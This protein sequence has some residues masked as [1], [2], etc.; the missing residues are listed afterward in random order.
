MRSTNFKCSVLK[1]KKEKSRRR[2][3]L[4]CCQ[5]HSHLGKNHHRHVIKHGTEFLLLRNYTQVK[6][7]IWLAVQ[8]P[9]LFYGKKYFQMKLKEPYRRKKNETELTAGV[10]E[11]ILKALRSLNRTLFNQTRQNANFQGNHLLQ[12]HKNKQIT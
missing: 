12:N 11:K 5:S 10:L 3:N 1:E 8:V 9:I 4:M 2:R 6:I 7:Y